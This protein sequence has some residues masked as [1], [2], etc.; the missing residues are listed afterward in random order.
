MITWKLD[1][2]ID[3]ED[4]DDRHGD[5]KLNGEDGIDLPDE[6]QP[7]TFLT[8]GVRESPI[9]ALR[10]LYV[11]QIVIKW[12]AHSVATPAL[13]CHKEPAQGT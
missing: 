2:S 5:H 10:V 7:H 6:A 8:E 12:E 1:H 11:F 4:A 9:A 3:P 13:L